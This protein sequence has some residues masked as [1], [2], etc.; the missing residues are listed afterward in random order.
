M[1]MYRVYGD[2]LGDGKDNTGLSDAHVCVWR[3]FSEALREGK[4]NQ[5]LIVICVDVIVLVFGCWCLLF[6]FLCLVFCIWYLVFVFWCL[7]VCV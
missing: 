1:H 7:V 6:V 2:P 5:D 4:D 3:S